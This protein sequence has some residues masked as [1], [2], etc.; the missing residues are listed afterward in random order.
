MQ[1]I[2]KKIEASKAVATMIT[3]LRSLHK[4]ASI[5]EETRCAT[6]NLKYA[7]SQLEFTRSAYIQRCDF[8]VRFNVAVYQLSVIPDLINTILRS[9]N[10]EGSD[11]VK[12]M[13]ETMDKFEK[14][15]KDVLA[16]VDD[17]N[18]QIQ[19]EENTSKVLN[20]FNWATKYG[21]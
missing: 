14:T 2:Q 17:L 8:E 7:I 11:R 6:E 3:T 9:T 5:V 1:A 21:F 15:N 18:Q 19:G 10:M 20:N 12:I 4:F 13:T 16:L